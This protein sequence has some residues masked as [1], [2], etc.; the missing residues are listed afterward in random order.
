M[1]TTTSPMLVEERE[2]EEEAL[3]AVLDKQ[4]AAPSWWPAAQ[5]IM[6]ESH[7]ARIRKAEKFIIREERRV[8]AES[9]SGST[10]SPQ[11]EVDQPSG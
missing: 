6:G 10:S 11:H 2:K 4:S 8:V 1:V 3:K 7:Y 5:G 9:A